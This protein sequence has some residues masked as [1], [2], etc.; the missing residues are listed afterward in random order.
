MRPATLVTQLF[1][2]RRRSRTD[3]TVRWTILGIYCA[4]IFFVSSIPGTEIS[5]PV[6]DRISHT[7]VFMGLGVLLLAAF[8]SV[9]RQWSRP[10]ITGVLASGIVYGALDEWHQSFVPYR[11][12]SMKDLLFDTIGV[13]LAIVVVRVM[14]RWSSR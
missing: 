13:I 14:L 4:L 6:D 10:A 1:A 5:A 9:I 12:S 8:A 2:A 3:L 11:D 7:V